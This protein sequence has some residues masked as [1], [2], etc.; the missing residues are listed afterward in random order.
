[1]RPF[2]SAMIALAFSWSFQKV[3]PFISCSS[4]SRWD[5]FSPKSKRVSKLEDLVD[6]AFG[7]TLQFGIQGRL[8]T[9]QEGTRSAA[10]TRIVGYDDTGTGTRFVAPHSIRHDRW[11]PGPVEPRDEG[12][13]VGGCPSQISS[14]PAQ[15]NGIGRP[16][17]ALADRRPA[18]R[19]R[20]DVP[21]RL[22]GG[23][24]TAAAGWSSG[25]R[26]ST[27]PGSA[28]RRC[29]TPSRTCAGSA[30]TGTRDRTSAV[31]SAPYV[32]SERRPLY[33]AAL[34]RLK[35]AEMVYPCTCTRAD[36]ERAASAPHPED[37]GPSYPGTCAHRSAADADVARRSTVR[38]AIPRPA[39]SRSP[40]RTSSWV[41]SRSTRPGSGG[42]FIVARHG[43]G[44]SYQLAV[45]VDDAAMGVNQ[46]IRGSDLVHQHA[47]TDPALPGPRPD[48]ARV[49]ARPPGPRA[50][51]PP[52]GQ[53]GRLVEARHAP[54]G[55]SRSPRCSSGR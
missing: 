40:G 20:P 37:E 49:R 47:A 14:N 51:R 30:W 32:Q 44:P 34:D 10:S 28:P 5:C 54:R 22:A 48:S 36:I 50:R 9:L 2:T 43:V 7:R 19:S 6:H 1:M 17:G 41:T 35:A 27:R 24:I 42:D 52:A 16:P 55:G 25:S 12:E 23:P 38:L 26:T 39:G 21:D 53:A 15:S 11:P 46:V 18:P 13:S 3:G 4:A 33:E 29:R 8:L 31:A 45:V